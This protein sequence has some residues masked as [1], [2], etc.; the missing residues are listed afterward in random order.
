MIVCVDLLRSKDSI[1]TLTKHST[2][3]WFQAGEL[4]L[5]QSSHAKFM[6]IIIEGTAREVKDVDINNRNVWPIDLE[7][8]HTC[9][10][11]IS[12]SFVVKEDIIKG[13][14]FGER[15]IIKD[16]PSSSSFFA[17][18]KCSCLL[19]QK[20]ELLQCMSDSTSPVTHNCAENDDCLYDVV[21]EVKGGPSST[22]EYKGLS[23]NP[24]Q[25]APTIKSSRFTKKGKN[26]QR[27]KRKDIGEKK[28]VDEKSNLQIARE[29]FNMFDVNGDGTI[30]PM[31]LGI[32]LKQM[33]TR[34]N[35][36]EAEDLVKGFDVQGDGIDF[37]EFSNLLVALQFGNF[38]SGEKK[39]KLKIFDGS[40][41]KE[42]ERTEER[43]K[44][45]HDKF[46]NISDEMKEK[47]LN[48]GS[49]NTD[50]NTSPLSSPS[51]FKMSKSLSCKTDV[52]TLT[53]KEMRRRNRHYRLL[54]SNIM[55][56]LKLKPLTF[57]H[58]NKKLEKLYKKWPENNFIGCKKNK[59]DVDVSPLP[60]LN[61]EGYEPS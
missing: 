30:S 58:H 31:E 5:K 52:E 2:R 9:T 29:S 23:L 51:P 35:Q 49:E 14:W 22:I 19:L 53:A 50:D 28:N 34:I 25:I 6:Y 61:E 42:A 44:K 48:S 38:G 17:K 40:L 55:K 15:S 27:H 18:T 41:Q 26:K 12:K 36:S 1:S 11:K 3:K 33:G 7:T 57:E 32:A 47:L 45:F 37:S 13:E 4:I 54:K 39:S 21:K 8:W 46:Y 60:N 16:A 20:D 59:N 43:D 24:H 10:R 56:P